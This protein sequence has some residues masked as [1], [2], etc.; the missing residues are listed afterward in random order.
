M[1]ADGCLN[2]SL[3]GRPAD[4]I[5]GLHGWPELPLGC[6]AT[7]TGPLLAATDEF[8]LTI[9]GS[10][11][12][13]A[14]PHFGTD[15]IVAAAHIV[16]AL[17]TIASRRASPLDSVVVTVGSIHAGHANNVIPNEA[18][19]TGTIRTLK[20]STRV[21]AEQEFRRIVSGVA[22]SL[23]AIADIQW[24]VG[25]PVTENAPAPT[26]RFRRIAREALGD[27]RVLERDQP[28]MGGED[29]SFYGM[30]VP[31]CFF[32]LGLK[33]PGVEHP[34]KLHTP[35][36]DFNDDALP[37]GIEIMTKLAAAPL[38]PMSR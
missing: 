38:E 23:G 37:V 21:M 35:E 5:Y 20:P 1:C 6:V 3:L 10:G 31:A 16:T 18:V 12:H 24:H 9:R 27:E 15:P 32:F 34:A 29:F 2:G 30:H 17:Q 22:H 8:T 11:C 36:F 13:A 7:R 19:M 33:P 25:Y 26:D 14:Y 4:V 28:T